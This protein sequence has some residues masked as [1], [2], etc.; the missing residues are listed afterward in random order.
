[1]R[2]LAFGID[3]NVHIG[4]YQCDNICILF[5]Q[6]RDKK[7]SVNR[8]CQLKHIFRRTGLTLYELCTSPIIG[9]EFT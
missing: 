2:E 4:F 8:V 6:C 7:N 5:I 1:M 3:E 9:N